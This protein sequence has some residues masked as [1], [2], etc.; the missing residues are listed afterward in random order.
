VTLILVVG[1]GGVFVE[2]GLE[3]RDDCFRRSKGGGGSVRVVEDELIEERIDLVGVR[4][5]SKLQENIRG[6]ITVSHF[7]DVE[8]SKRSKGNSRE[9]LP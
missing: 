6:E 7:Q 1:G 4:D 3:G 9:E 8:S 2:D 5:V